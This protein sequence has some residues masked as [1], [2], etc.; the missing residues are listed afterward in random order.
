[1]RVISEFTRGRGEQA[2]EAD[3]S[4]RAT[5]Q[6]MTAQTPLAK[7]MAI[8]IVTLG[9]AGL[10]CSVPAAAQS[11]IRVSVNA[12]T[13]PVVVRNGKG[14]L[15]LDLSQANFRIFDNGVPQKITSFDVGSAPISA[16]I[17]VET[18][19][20]VAGL[21]PEISST[22]TLFTQTVLGADGDAAVIG[23]DDNVT[24]LQ[25]F[26]G[27]SAAIEKTFTHLTEGTS[28]ARLYDGMARAVQLLRA[29]PDTRR[30]VLITLAESIDTGSEEKLGIVLRDAQ[31]ANIVIYSIGLSTAKAMA[32][33][34][35]ANLPP[36]ATPPG[37]FSLPPMPGTPQTPDTD[38][39]RSGEYINLTHLA[40]LV[41]KNVDYAVRGQPLE[42]ATTATGGLF[43][44]VSKDSQMASA[45]DEI[46]GELHAQYMISYRPMGVGSSDYH[47]IKVEVVGKRGL[48]A[49]SRPGY[50]LEAPAQG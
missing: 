28:G 42:I 26:T 34:E 16:A 11:N 14:A 17:V 5:T 32:R 21:L 35:E 33:T 40:E 24:T 20:R 47:Q 8:G 30:R 19:S 49:R 36:S 39:I 44:S 18:S 43:Q 13:T 4:M 23:F 15:Q 27:D 48:K 31:L 2:P 22:G 10:G 25:G 29:R 46:S 6:T 45:I 38:A 41:V 50:Y 3:D 7:R 12:V 1:M 9:L 37:T